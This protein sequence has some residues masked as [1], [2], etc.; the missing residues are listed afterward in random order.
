MKEM[1]RVGFPGFRIENRLVLEPGEQ[2]VASLFRPGEIFEGK[3]LRRMDPHQAVLQLKGKTLRVETR[4]PL[5]DGFGLFEVESVAPPVTLRFL[6]RSGGEFLLAER[7]VRKYLSNDMPFE[8]WAEGLSE[9]QKLETLEG[10]TKLRRSLNEMLRALKGFSIDPADRADPER[11]V[12]AILRSGLFL[13]NTLATS[14]GLEGE[15]KMEA[16]LTRDLK[17]LGLQ[18]IGELRS[19]L[20]GK[21]LDPETRESARTLLQGLDRLIQKIELYQLLN[22]TALDDHA[23]LLLLPVWFEERLHLVELGISLPAPKKKNED[24]AISLLFLLHLPDLGR[25]RIEVTLRKKDLLGSFRVSDQEVEAWLHQN[26]G[27]LAE[28]L[29]EIGYEAN[30]GVSVEAPQTDAPSLIARMATQWPFGFSVVI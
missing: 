8:G 20:D 16:L 23:R 2:D 5:P 6:G 9:L 14:S 26:L 15:G 25:M 19:L 28:R 21:V 13:E 3:I 29:R 18:L 10:L 27:E 4:V 12:R 24:D 7:L 11:L 17:S 22:L 1:D 30:L